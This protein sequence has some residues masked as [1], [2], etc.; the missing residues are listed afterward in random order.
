M[1]FSVFLVS[2]DIVFYVF[3]VTGQFII[4][5]IIIIIWVLCSTFKFG[6]PFGA[7]VWVEPVQVS[8]GARWLLWEQGIGKHLILK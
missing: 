4:I 5:I 2:N 6:W 1:W 3:F 8:M 7:V